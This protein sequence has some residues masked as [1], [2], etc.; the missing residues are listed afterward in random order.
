MRYAGCNIKVK[1]EIEM[2][3]DRL[4]WFWT[5]LVVSYIGLWLIV[6]F[7][8]WGGYPE[9]C[10]IKIEKLQKQVEAIEKNYYEH[11]RQIEILRT[12]MN[13]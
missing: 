8:F 2:D 6:M 11:D 9:G 4:T 5:F 3:E 13:Q 10:F 12:Q 1:G 7:G